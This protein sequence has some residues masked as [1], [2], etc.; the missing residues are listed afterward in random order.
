ML[1]F[2]NA[3]NKE[4]IAIKIDHIKNTAYSLLIL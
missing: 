4:Y 1:I 3:T 2:K